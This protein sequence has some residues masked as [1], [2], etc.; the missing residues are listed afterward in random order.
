MLTELAADSRKK[1]YPDVWGL[2]FLRPIT[3][4]NMINYRVESLYNF[5]LISLIGSQI[6]DEKIT[7]LPWLLKIEIQY[8]Q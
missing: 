3:H 7:V 4:L 8:K 2:H 1:T 5:H 6:R